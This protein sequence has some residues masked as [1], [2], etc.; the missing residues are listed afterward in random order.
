M[1]SLVRID[2]APVDRNRKKKKKSSNTKKKIIKE[3]QYE[4]IKKVFRADHTISHRGK[5][6]LVCVYVCMFSVIC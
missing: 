2:R 5:K 1:S 3:M 6:N 4:C